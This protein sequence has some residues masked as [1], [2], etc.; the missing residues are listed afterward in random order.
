MGQARL[1]CG[2]KPNSHRLGEEVGRF[3]VLVL[4]HRLRK[5]HPACAAFIGAQFG[6][7]AEPGNGSGEPHWLA[8]V[9]TKRGWVGRKVTHAALL[10]TA[11]GSVIDKDQFR[12]TFLFFA[13]WAAGGGA[14]DQTRLRDQP[15]R[16]RLDV[17]I[18][19]STWENRSC[20]VQPSRL[21]RKGAGGALPA[22]VVGP[23][24]PGHKEHDI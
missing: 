5:A 4:F 18:L 16:R 1:G 6:E 17:P 15:E 19:F 13:I 7:A 24:N 9:R 8:T 2:V 23:P 11:P 10:P 14:G 21:P 20:T 12:L 3:L 22:S